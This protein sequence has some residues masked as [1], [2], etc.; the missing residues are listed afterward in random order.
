MF[1]RLKS[2]GYWDLLDF[3]ASRLGIYNGALIGGDSLSNNLYTF[4]R[5]S[6]MMVLR[7]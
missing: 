2:K 3:P 5:A 4:S 7:S 1:V 6:M